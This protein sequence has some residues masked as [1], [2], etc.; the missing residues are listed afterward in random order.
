MAGGPAFGYAGGMSLKTIIALL[1]R[2]DLF[3]GL[4]AARLEVIAFT[5]ERAVFEPGEL[6]FEAGEEGHEAYLILEGAA[7]MVARLGGGR[8]ETVS[9]DAGALVGEAALIAPTSAGTLR[10][11]DMRATTRIEA[12]SISRYL[13]QRLMQEFP[14]MAGAVATALAQ[15]LSQTSGE[16]AQ[17]ADS[18][19]AMTARRN[20]HVE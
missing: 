16:M 1:R 8:V 10:R 13:F 9:V 15:R 12:L 14:E 7:Q 18:L 19:A 4:P 11:S 5:A 3:A 6:L 17:L 2:H 20:G